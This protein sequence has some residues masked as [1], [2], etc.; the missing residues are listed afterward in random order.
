MK[1][2][3]I[4]LTV[5]SA[6][7]C[8]ASPAVAQQFPD[9]GKYFEY[10]NAHHGAI[11]N[12]NMEYIQYAV[13][14][15]DLMEI[16]EKRMELITQIA[17]SILNVRKTPPYEEDSK[18]KDELESV[19]KEYL[20]SF[21]I[22]FN[23]VNILKKESQNSYEAMEAYLNAQDEAEK[24]IAQA[25]ERFKE[26]QIAFAAKHNITLIESEKNTEVD[27]LNRLN[28]YQ[29]VVFLKYFK[30]SKKAA[31]F[32]DAMQNKDEPL[33]KKN[34]AELLDDCKKELKT[35]QLM[36]DFNGD[37]DYRDSAIKLVRFYLDL[38][39]NGYK[40]MMDV[41]LKESLSEEDV[42]AYNKVIQHFND[43]LPPLV[44]GFNQATQ[45]LLRKNVPRPAIKTKQ[46]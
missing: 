46:T 38:A 29:R 7:L 18:M 17:E 23:E 8:A 13:H 45:N 19:L 26:A 1:V 39:E 32:D 34:L 2:L 14:S 10:I 12:K 21:R 20:E 44:N 3:S 5:L 22:D 9:P 15:N 16:E 37:T 28:R 42:D 40:T 43:N 25:A 24:K 33:M 6:V 41:T 36:P 11:V 30:I 31:E 4:M 27:Q 35:L